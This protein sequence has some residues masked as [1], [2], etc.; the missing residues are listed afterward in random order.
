MQAGLTLTTILLLQSPKWYITG[1]HHLTW[2][3]CIFYL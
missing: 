2:L 3:K 1:M